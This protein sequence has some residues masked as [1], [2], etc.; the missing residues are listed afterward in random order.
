[1]LS[2]DRETTSVCQEYNIVCCLNLFTIFIFTCI[3]LLYYNTLLHIYIQMKNNKTRKVQE[4]KSSGLSL[5]FHV[6]R[7]MRLVGGEFSS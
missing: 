4:F 5:T 2:G 6:A 1:M 7:Y 3:C